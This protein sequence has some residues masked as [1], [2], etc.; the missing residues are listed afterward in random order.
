M[1]RDDQ[2]DRPK[3]S[4]REID[5][6][7]EKGTSRSSSGDRGAER[8]QSSQAYRSYKTQLNKLFDGGA[9][10]EALSGKLA[11]TPVASEAKQRKEAVA[12]ILKALKPKDV[13]KAVKDYDAAFGGM[14][15][16][17]EALGKIL[18]LT[19]EG[20]VLRALDKIAELR[21]AG[22]LQRTASLKARL[23]SVQI[24]LDEPDIISAAK[25]L[26]AQL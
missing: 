19:D 26:L 21:A 10:P 24:S 12:G 25:A 9:L 15:D 20:L 16:D 3:K 7:R 6:G 11:D 13:V 1:P 4:W 8:Q 18:D 17:E 2:G 22:P 23:K 14:P 5:A